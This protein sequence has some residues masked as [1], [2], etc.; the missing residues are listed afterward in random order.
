MQAMNEDPL[1][2]IGIP[3]F[4]GASYLRETLYSILAQSYSNIDVVVRD[5]ASTDNSL[6]I[7]REFARKDQ[8]VRV[9][10][11]DHNEGA[12]KN[13]NAVFDNAPGK[14][15]KWA[16]ADDV[17]APTF[18]ERCVDE[19]EASNSV[20]LA[21]PKTVIIDRIGQTVE[22]IDD[23]LNLGVDDAL[24][25]FRNIRFQLQECN[26]IFGVISTDVLRRTRLIQ[27][28]KSADAHLL[29]EL[30]L[31]GRFTQVEQPLFYRRMHDAAS[32]ADSG[33]DWQRTFYRADDLARPLMSVWRGIMHDLGSIR[34]A[35]LSYRERASATIFT[36]RAAYWGRCSLL[37]EAL[38]YSRYSARSLMSR[39]E[40]INVEP[41]D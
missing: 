14:Y 11:A 31:Y 24:T 30:A 22:V 3:V 17:L 4:N 35:P 28:Y 6:E 32:S 13:Y 27:P 8:R 9:L 25:R 39:R 2:T 23:E 38:A 15:F 41:T 36:C 5:N 33:E 20:M 29:A 12:A 19:L 34:R 16:A 21:Y 7:A 26:A 1:V 18:I 37:S 10:G 40:S